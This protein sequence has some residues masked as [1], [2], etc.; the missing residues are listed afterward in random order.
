MLKFKGANDH[1]AKIYVN[2][3]GQYLVK[4]E[5]HPSEEKTRLWANYQGDR[6]IGPQG[7]MYIVTEI[8][9]NEDCRGEAIVKASD[10]PTEDE[11]KPPKAPSLGL[12]LI[13]AFQVVKFSSNDTSVATYMREIAGKNICREFT[14][15]K[16]LDYG[17]NSLC[18]LSKKDTN[19]WC[20]CSPLR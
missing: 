20:D 17:E 4:V 16:K 5:D 14:P 12:R 15:S 6:Y 2:N 13:C 10:L 7:I 8:P 11:E 18:L 9:E 1:G 19:F 3:Q